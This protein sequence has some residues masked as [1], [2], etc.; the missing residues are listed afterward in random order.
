MN[1]TFQKNSLCY[2]NLDKCLA[3]DIINNEVD[4]ER[5]FNYKLI[6]K[7]T[8]SIY[9]TS[10]NDSFFQKQSLQKLQPIDDLQQKQQLELSAEGETIP[11]VSTTTTSTTM[12]ESISEVSTSSSTMESDDADLPELSDISLNNLYY[13]ELDLELLNL[14]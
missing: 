11:T 7:N 8:N 5:A 10:Q 1:F 13:I 6:D 2:H 4:H 9:N 3:F 12:E 14:I